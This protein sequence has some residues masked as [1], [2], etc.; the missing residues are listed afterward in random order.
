MGSTPTMECHASS[1]ATPI[2][3]T[4]NFQCMK[5]TALR[6]WGAIGLSVLSTVVG[7]EAL[8]DNTAPKTEADKTYTGTVSSVSPEGGVLMMRDFFWDKKFNLGSQCTYDLMNKRATSAGGLHN[9]Q[10]VMLTYVEQDG[11]RVVSRVEQIPEHYEGWVKSVDADDC[12]ERL[13]VTLRMRGVDREFVIADNCQV[14]LNNKRV[15]RLSDLKKGD[16]VT[17]LYETPDGNLY[18]RQIAQMSDKFEGELTAIDVTENT[19]KAKTLFDSKKFELGSD[20]AIET[21]TKTDARLKDLRPGDK[22]MVSY[23]QVNGVNVVNRIVR[24]EAAAFTAQN[25]RE[26]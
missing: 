6:T 15:G 7:Y 19:V 9:G 12:R 4:L 16:R 14:M 26:D 21:E 3:R 18:A 20:C 24:T 17:V 13:T 10:K 22:V 25:Y 5:T 2:F 1:V 8:A 11:V 23:N